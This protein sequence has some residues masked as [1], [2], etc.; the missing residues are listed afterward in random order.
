MR[1][2]IPK[3][4]LKAIICAAFAS[5]V[6]AFSPNAATAA[7]APS[8]LYNKSVAIN[9][10]ESGTYKRI[11]DGVNTNPV[12][13]FQATLYVSSAGRPFLRVT[14]TSGRY[15]KNRE[16]GPETNSGGVQF[17]GNTLVMT[18]ENIG[19]ARRI[20]ATFDGS[21]SSCTATV[22]IGK[23]SPNARL[24]GFDGAEYQ[25]ITMQPGAASC[26]IREGNAL[27]N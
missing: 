25:I 9:W 4:F 19:I 21:F 3:A 12:G 16:A 8:Q 26:S 17:A 2:E 18:R 6:V 5:I 20:I 14:S 10:G 15:G 22:T 23:V 13:Q 7:G 27:A 1:K 11:S 24:T